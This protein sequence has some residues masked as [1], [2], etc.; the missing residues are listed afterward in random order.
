MEYLQET[1]NTPVSGEGGVAVVGGGIAGAAAALSA[2]R[3]GAQVTLIDRGYLLG[4]LATAGL[5]AIY[6]PLCDG[7]GRQVSFGICDELFR[8]S[9]CEGPSGRV[10]TAWLPGGDPASRAFQ[11]LKVQYDPQLFALQIEQL[12]TANGVR[13]LFGTSVCAVYR[14]GGAVDAL[15]LENCA[16]RSALRVD[17][18]VD[19]T[20]DAALCA[21][22]G[23]PTVRSARGNRL[24][25]WYY[26]MENGENRLHI[27]GES[28]EAA[29]AHEQAA[30]KLGGRRFDGL[31]PAQLSA[32]L[33]HAHEVQREAFLAAGGVG[34][35]HALTTLPTLPQLRMTRRLALPFAPT[36]A[37]AQA[38]FADSIGLIG[39]WRRAGPIYELPLAALCGRENKN[40]FVAGRCISVADDLWEATRVIPA[41][42]VTGEAA[43]LAAAGVPV[44]EVL[45]ARCVP[46]HAS[47]LPPR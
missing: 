25:A 15:I 37:E 13:I 45:A 29:P 11:R 30:E 31:D 8:L 24:S 18:A 39:D 34:P 4:G 20:G 41:A 46:L 3:A 12:L 17:A 42:A 32:A 5:I 44:A 40:L 7:R 9:I 16:G 14:A 36:L 1:L 28:D 21:L 23:E 6:L 2:A 47:Q 35:G 26:S 27:L 38:G 19:A 22:A 10:P 43:G 33:C